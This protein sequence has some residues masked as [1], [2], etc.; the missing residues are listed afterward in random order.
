VPGVAACGRCRIE[1]RVTQRRDIAESDSLIT[2]N[3][4]CPACGAWKDWPIVIDDIGGPHAEC[5]KCGNLWPATPEK[6][7]VAIQR[8]MWDLDR[9]LDA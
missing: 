5:Y 4:G 3:D 2:Y 8:A 1:Y 9:A 6:L 7:E